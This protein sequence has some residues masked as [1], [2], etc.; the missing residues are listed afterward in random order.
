MEFGPVAPR[1]ASGCVLGHQL[2][3]SDRTLPKG[4]RIT[5]ADV[6]AM[7][8]A[9]IGSVTVARLDPGDV[10][11]GDAALR[12]ARSIAGAGVSCEGPFTGRANV[13]ATT[14]G[15]VTVDAEGIAALLG[16]DERLTV[17]TLHPGASVRD[18]Q[19]VATAKVIPFA[20]PEALVVRWE[21]AAALTP[22]LCVR[23]FAPRAA[24]LVLTRFPDTSDAVLER[25]TRS[26]A[27]RLEARG[28]SLREERRCAHDAS[29]VEHEIRAAL[30]NGADL[31][32]VL[33]ASQIADRS[34]VVP[35]AVVAAGGQVHRLGLPVDPGNLTM[36]GT[37]GSTPVLGVPGCARSLRPSGFDRILDLVLAG[38]AP[39]L[40][41][42]DS[43][44]VGG[45]LKEIASRP[46][47]RR[48][49]EDSAP[50]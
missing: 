23:P 42:V 32:T 43:M 14:A 1:D 4:H 38:T 18:G 34:D 3:L 10:I 8:A 33:G 27:T 48:R 12:L 19:L 50:S 25:A 20:V 49:D 21:A 9:S 46:R 15:I 24:A 2:R 31:V 29:A 28:S 11:E 37:I 39:D 45:L 44:G 22:P 6:E 26:M 16:I 30:A 17:A 41:D 5:S 13:R 35:A 40:I 7:E 36:I 47:P